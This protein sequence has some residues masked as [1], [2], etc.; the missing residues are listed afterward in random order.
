MTTRRMVT[1]HVWGVPG[2]AVPGALVRVATD[3]PALRRTPGLR[4]AKL[5]GTGRGRTFTVRDADPRRW[6]LLAVWDDADDAD[7]FEHGPL[8]RRWR[9]PAEEE[10]SARLRPLAAR[11]RW[12]RAE[13][14]GRPWPQRWE[15]P[16]AA[17]TRARLAPRKALAFWRAVPPVAADLHAGPGL[18]LALG[19]GEAPIGLQ[20]TFSVWESAAA[21]NAFAY[22]RAPHAAV[23]EQTARQGWYAEELFARF[24]L[25][26]AGGTLG[27]RDPLA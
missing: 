22:T 17:I 23:I 12:S 16:V 27:G 25:L 5:L 2:R 24:G 11:G 21:L 19:I 3:R 18:R 9:R 14:F 13:P 26:S 8:L 20:G 6:A 4:F 7:A 15:G 10:W 1:L